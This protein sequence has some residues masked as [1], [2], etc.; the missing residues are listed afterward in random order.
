MPDVFVPADTTQNTQL[1]D[2]LE[3]PAFYRLCDRP[4]ATRNKQISNADFIAQYDITDTGLH[5]FIAYAS[6]TVKNIVPRDLLV[7]RDVIKTLIKANAARFKWGNNAYYRVL[8][9]TM[10]RLKRRCFNRCANMRICR[11]A[12]KK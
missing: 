3:E 2:D 5:N 7:S 12:E 11:C 10:L 9:P 6:Q 8:T 4:A 1:V